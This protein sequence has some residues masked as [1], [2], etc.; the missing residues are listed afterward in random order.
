[1]ALAESG[2]KMTSTCTTVVV[3]IPPV[4]LGYRGRGAR[5][6]PSWTPS[7]WDTILYQNKDAW[8]SGF[9]T[10]FTELHIERFVP[11]YRQGE[12][13]PRGKGKFSVRPPCR[14]GK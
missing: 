3:E 14:R 7:F 1:M 6:S 13:T 5:R 11:R 12:Q 9:K 8:N 4:Q 2:K 10:V